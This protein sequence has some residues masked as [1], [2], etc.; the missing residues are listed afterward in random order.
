[1]TK[2]FSK[3]KSVHH[4]ESHLVADLSKSL[5]WTDS[6]WWLVCHVGMDN[7]DGHVLESTNR[8]GSYW[9]DEFD[10]MDLGN[11]FEREWIEF[12]LPL[13]R[14][15][16]VSIP[17]DKYN[18]VLILS[19][20]CMVVCRVVQMDEK[21]MTWCPIGFLWNCPSMSFLQFATIDIEV[22]FSTGGFDI[23]NDLMARNSNTTIQNPCVDYKFSVAILLYLIN[24]EIQKY[25]SPS[26]GIQK[27]DPIVHIQP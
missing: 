17:P 6:I 7:P 8:A 21:F 4:G 25:T 9:G 26:W 13:R 23:S 12:E 24:T 18:R 22:C 16:H 2:A 20:F 14:C 19:F 11:G 10:G 1:M 5:V 27:S 15:Y 3:K